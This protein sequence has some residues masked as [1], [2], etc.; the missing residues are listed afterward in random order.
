[1]LAN[2]DEVEFVRLI[3][4]LHWA[5]IF[6]G[7]YNLGSLFPQKYFSPNQQRSFG[8]T[9]YIC[10]LWCRDFFFESRK[11]F[12]QVENFFYGVENYFFDSNSD[13]KS[14]ILSSSRDFF[15]L[16]R[17]FF[18]RVEN[19]QH[20]VPSFAAK[21]IKRYGSLQICWLFSLFIHRCPSS[22]CWRCGGL[23]EVS[24]VY[25]GLHFLYRTIHSSWKRQKYGM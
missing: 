25:T 14:R 19:T 11:F 4:F 1:M 9:G 16:S 2:L 5:I 18:H 23:G 15:F 24:V 8:R 10:R 13:N 21:T 3:F 6:R 20:T 12:S 22:S 7:I 17:K